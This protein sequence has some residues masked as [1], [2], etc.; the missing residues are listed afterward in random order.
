MALPAPNYTQ[1]PNVF[2]DE[3]FK[4]LTEG[5]LRIVLVLVRQTFGW[6]KPADRISLSQLADKTGMPKTSVCRSLSTLLA[7]NLIQKH[8]FGNPGQERVYY[9]LVVE[10]EKQELPPIPTD[11]IESE[12]EMALISNNLYQSLKETP[13]VS[14]RDPPQSLKETHKINSSKETIQKKQQQASPSAAASFTSKDEEKRPKVYPCLESIDIPLLDKM[15]ITKT[16]DLPKVLHALKWLEK[17]DKPLTKGIAA[18]LKW[19]CKIQPEI[20][21]PKADIEQV[22]KAYALQYDG[23]RVGNCKVE[24]LS[25]Q[26]EIDTGCSYTYVCLPY[27]AKGFMEQFTNALRK[28]NFPILGAT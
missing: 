18:A 7:K 23:K 5:E 15:E 8:K 21:V 16:Y 24:A 25:K 12:E 1:A 14:E 4:T 28:N 3:V 11:G 13:P 22:N 19:A 2:F 10:Q 26:V 17:N 20:P 9:A 27:T 6:H